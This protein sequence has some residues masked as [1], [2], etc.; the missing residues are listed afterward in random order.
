MMLLYSDCKRNTTELCDSEL[1]NC[2]WVNLFNRRKKTRI[3]NVVNKIPNSK[4]ELKND[5]IMKMMCDDTDNPIEC[6]KCE[7]R[8]T[9]DF[10]VNLF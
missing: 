2:I 5:T 10:Y 1:C 6:N 3:L 9:D 8:L 4:C 7:A